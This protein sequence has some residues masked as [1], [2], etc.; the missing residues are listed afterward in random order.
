MTAVDL[1]Q[2]WR[3]RE[4]GRIGRQ[5]S[6]GWQ[7]LPTP[8]RFGIVIA[9]FFVLAV[10]V[11]SSSVASVMAPQSDWKT[12]LFNP[13]GIYVLLAVGLNIVVGLAGMLDLGYVAFFAVGAYAL[14]LLATRQ[15][16]NFWFILPSAV[17]LAAFAGILLGAPTL[18]LR[19]DYL[20]IVTLGFGQIISVAANNFTF[21]GGPQGITSIPHPPSIGHLKAFSYGVRDARP[22]Y[23]LVLALIF[24][25]IFGVRRL[26]RSRIGRAWVAIREDEDVAELMG[27]PTYRFRLWAFSA[28]A[29]IGGVAGVMYASK[30]TFITPGNFTYSISII[31]LASVVLGGSGNLTGVI[32]GAFLVAWLPERLRWFADYRIM[33]FGAAL[34]AMMILRPEGILPS[35][36]RRAEMA[37]VGGGGMNAALLPPAAEGEH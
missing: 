24:L 21:D 33:I 20:A 4:R 1:Q 2:R 31:I 25:V 12:I 11:P 23:Y 8:A 34:V 32:L 19:G 7:R 28:G 9:A 30:P 37:D 6:N 17:V 29:A 35:R 5:A 26:E 14:G 16:W 10:L 36:R 15:H 22:Y 3:Q 13:I 18:R 27:V